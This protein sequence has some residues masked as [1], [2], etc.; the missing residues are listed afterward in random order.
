MNT[1][2]L[3]EFK[4]KVQIIEQY[5]GEL[6]FRATCIEEG[7]REV[8]GPNVEVS[9]KAL[10][11]TK[12]LAASLLLVADEQQHGNILCDLDNIYMK[13]K[14]HYPKDVMAEFNY[15]TN[16]QRDRKKLEFC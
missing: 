3:D 7:R 11:R 2:F 16:Y 6:G 13:G 9:F 1:T 14:H 15:L 10:L 4:L 12:Y 8:T 5:G